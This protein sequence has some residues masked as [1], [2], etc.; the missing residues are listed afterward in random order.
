MKIVARIESDTNIR[1]IFNQLINHDY[2]AVALTNKVIYTYF[3]ERKKEDIKSILV[4]A[5]TKLRWD[6]GSSSESIS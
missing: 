3:D 4:T 6:Y 2:E 1:E 5:R